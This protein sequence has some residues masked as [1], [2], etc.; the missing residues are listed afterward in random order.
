MQYL[1]L[2]ERPVFETRGLP[3]GVHAVPW[4]HA[5]DERRSV[6]GGVRRLRSLA[7]VL[8]QQRPDVVLAG[9]LQTGSAM[10]AAVSRRPFVAMSWGS[11][12]LVDADRSPMS[13]WVTRFALRRSGG[14]FGDCQAVRDKVHALVSYADDRIV[15]FP[16]GI[17]LD[18]F[19][20]DR[21]D[22]G[23]P[24][25]ELGW[26]DKLVFISTRTWEPLYA[27]D[28]LVRAFASVIG[29]CPDARLLLLGDGSQQQSIRGL[30]GDLGIERFVETPG[31][32]AYDHLPRYFQSAD[33]YV[34]TALSDGTS[35]SLLEAMACGLPVIV[36]DG[37]GNVEWVTADVNG[38][39]VPPGDETALARAL[40]EAATDRDRRLRFGQANAPI[41][42]ARADWNHNFP[43]LVQLLER[44]STE[45]G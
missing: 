20:P 21:S 2:R 45:H 18:H 38:W 30:I 10:T 42:R 15:T 41:A 35:I 36:T 26:G 29:R 11:D 1:R 14:V 40:T 19:R 39:L 24:R 9:P 25:A 43:K 22:R 5:R 44:V 3:A 23:T 12:L 13:R 32:I 7:R 4:E 27:I 8:R 6:L 31:R 33:V 17:D 28:V 34:S 37:Y 16:W